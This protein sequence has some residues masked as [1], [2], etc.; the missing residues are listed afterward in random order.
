MNQLPRHVSVKSFMDTTYSNIRSEKLWRRPLINRDET[1]L[2]S[3]LS[4]LSKV[5]LK[6]EPD[7]LVWLPVKG[8]FSSKQFIQLCDHDPS[9]QV[10]P[11]CDWN[12][13]WATKLPPKLKIFF[14]K[15][16]RGILATRKFLKSRMSHLPERRND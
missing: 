5:D 6:A 14:W 12:I 10:I 3:L 1:N 15:L 13:L 7:M 9:N 8:N 16:Q 4:N 11:L 2:K